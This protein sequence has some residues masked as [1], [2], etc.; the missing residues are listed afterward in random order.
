MEAVTIGGT[1][2]KVGEVV[3]IREVEVGTTSNP[4]SPDPNEYTVQSSPVPAPLVPRIEDAI[5][6]IDDFNEQVEAIRAATQF[7]RVVSPEISRPSNISDALG[8]PAAPIR[9]ASSTTRRPAN[10][11]QP[12]TL[13]MKSTEPRPA[14]LRRSASLILKKENRPQSP[15]VEDP[16]ANN[17]TPRKSVIIPRPTSLLPPKPPAKS[18]KAPTVPVF[19]LPGEAVARRLKEQREARLS[20]QISSPVKPAAA[21]GPPRPKSSKPPTRPTFELPGEAISRRKR[22]AHEAK[23]RVQEEHER[24][25]REFKAKP[26]R[27]SIVPSTLPRETLTSR[28]RQSKAAVEE[29]MVRTGESMS[30]KRNSIMG[31]PR[32][33]SDISASNR[34]PQTRGRA[35]IDSSPVDMSRAT[36][37][38]TGSMSGK[39]STLSAEEL[40]LRGKEIYKRDNSM[41]EAKDRERRDREALARAAR[42]QAAERTRQASREWAMK[43]RQKQLAL[44]SALSPVKADA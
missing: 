15:P 19:E 35:M 31:T 23:L 34:S 28:A 42:E 38:S 6:A 8:V 10:K 39:R 16:A 43:Q 41:T 26:I 21:F 36:S 4:S 3:E 9:R 12:A 14:S 18:T 40:K 1:P 25:R 20:M 27:S 24:Q 5:G 32:P 37:S 44:T 13:R 17:A 30:S 33:S 22:E 2:S 29:T 11:N 7:N